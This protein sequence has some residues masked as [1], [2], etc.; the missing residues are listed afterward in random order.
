MLSG[1]A[2][3]SLQTPATDCRSPPQV[4]QSKTHRGGGIR[5]T[6]FHQTPWVIPMQPVQIL[7]WPQSSFG[8]F[9]TVLWKNPNELLGQANTT[10]GLG[11]TYSLKALKQWEGPPFS[12][13]QFSLPDLPSSGGFGGLH[14]RG[15]VCSPDS[16]IGVNLTHPPR[17]CLLPKPSG[18]GLWHKDV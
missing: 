3:L 5:E 15:G 17:G 6:S 8:F 16:P 1:L 12:A 14:V 2:R 4:C 9:H 7:G 10:A 18:V 11:T 13:K